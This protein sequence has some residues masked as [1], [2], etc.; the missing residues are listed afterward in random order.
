M[1]D[2]SRPNKYVLNCKQSKIGEFSNLSLNNKKLPF[3]FKLKSLVIICPNSPVVHICDG[4][5]DVRLRS[6]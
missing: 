3:V 1:Q 6:F 4:K 2:P 5:N